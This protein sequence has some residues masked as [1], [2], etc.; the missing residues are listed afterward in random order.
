MTLDTGE[1]DDAVGWRVRTAEVLK[2]CIGGTSDIVVG[3]SA[4]SR[5][6]A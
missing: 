1:N 6:L 5:D 3:T 2:S 4:A